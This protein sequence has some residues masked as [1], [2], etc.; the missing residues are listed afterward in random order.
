M[1]QRGKRNEVISRYRAGF[2]V[3]K[4]NFRQPPPEGGQAGQPLMD[5]VSLARL[6]LECAPKCRFCSFSCGVHQYP[7]TT[8]S[9]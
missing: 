9:Y 1:A 7:V 3:S 6:E 8:Y 4:R 2:A 5:H